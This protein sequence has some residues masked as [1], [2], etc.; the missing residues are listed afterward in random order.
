MKKKLFVILNFVALI[1]FSQ[2]PTQ[3]FSLTAGAIGATTADS[4]NY[5]A[6][7]V[8]NGKIY[9]VE[10][11]NSASVNDASGRRRG[12]LVRTEFTNRFS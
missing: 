2:S 6:V 10:S 7:D 9:Q 5:Y 8:T 11:L 1:S 4:S 12:L 3:A